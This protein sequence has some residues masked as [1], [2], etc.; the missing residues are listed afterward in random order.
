MGSGETLQ[1]YSDMYWDLYNKIGGDNE[2]VVAST[3]KMGLT[4]HSKQR[5]SLT[6]QALEN[7]H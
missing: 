3:F 4:F 1:S 2:H 5:D 6:M 7:M